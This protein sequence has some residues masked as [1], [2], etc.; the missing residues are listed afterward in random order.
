MSSAGTQAAPDRPVHMLT[1]TAMAEAGLGEVAHRSRPVDVAVLA[2]VDLV[3]T[4]ERAHRAAVLSL[5][6]D[7]LRRTFTLDELVSLAEAVR[8]Q[9]TDGRADEALRS[10][11]AERGRH[12]TTS[13]D[14]ADPVDAGPEAHHRMVHDVLSAVDRLKAS[15]LAPTGPVTRA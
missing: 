3:V 1:A 6:P 14:L 8:P 15:L 10:V 9:R 7:L 5:R 2:G 11:L 12:P 4:A 13:G